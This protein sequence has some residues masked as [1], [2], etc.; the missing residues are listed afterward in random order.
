MHM[1][2]HRHPER[3]LQHIVTMP[4]IYG[5]IIPLVILDISTEIYHRICF[6]AYGIPYVKRTVYISLD[7]KKLAYLT[8]QDKLNCMYCGYANG[9]LRY[10]SAIGQETE[11]YWCGIKHKAAPP[12]QELSYQKDF[13]AYGDEATYKNIKD[14]DY[15]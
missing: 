2:H 9:L 4:F 8:F 14:K 12:F 10:A 11:R 13:L 5:F 3:L 15:R 7:H 6:K 1:E